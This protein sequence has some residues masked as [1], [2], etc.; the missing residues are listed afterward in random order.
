MSPENK[1]KLTPEM[2]ASRRVDFWIALADQIKED[3]RIPDRLRMVLRQLELPPNPFIA[4]AFCKR[5]ADY[6]E[7]E[8]HL[9]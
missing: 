3:G 4:I 6:I 1:S 5:M 7:S 8:W 2:E 9:T